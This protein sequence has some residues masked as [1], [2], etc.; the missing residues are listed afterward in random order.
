[1]QL[2]TLRRMESTQRVR[3][4]LRLVPLNL[5][6]AIGLFAGISLIVGQFGGL[7]WLVPT[8]VIYILWSL[9]NAWLLVVQAIEEDL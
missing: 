5:A 4:A 1:M 9:N 8:V 6:T 3:W 7:F 2:Q